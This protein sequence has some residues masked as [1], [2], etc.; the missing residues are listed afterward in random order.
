MADLNCRCAVVFLNKTHRRLNVAVLEVSCRGRAPVRLATVEGVPERLV[1]GSVRHAVRELPEI[2]QKRGKQN[3]HSSMCKDLDLHA[4]IITSTTG[5]AANNAAHCAS[6][7]F[8]EVSEFSR[9][10]VVAGVPGCV[11]MEGWNDFLVTRRIAGLR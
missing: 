2:L 10:E 3:Q 1:F 11:W 7:G 8:G 6:S 4:R 5:S 9:F